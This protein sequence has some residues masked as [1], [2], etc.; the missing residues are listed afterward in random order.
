MNTYIYP[1]LLYIK[2]YNLNKK[3]GKN[4]VDVKDDAGNTIAADI[5]ISGMQ[6]IIPCESNSTVS[7]PAT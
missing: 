1:T 6:E 3:Q 4:L 2:T 7:K 5:K